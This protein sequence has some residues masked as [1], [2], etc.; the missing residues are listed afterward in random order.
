[1]SVLFNNSCNE[2]QAVNLLLAYTGNNKTWLAKQLNVTPQFL[3]LVHSNKP[4]K[5]YSRDHLI[6]ICKAFGVDWETFN[7][8]GCL[9]IKM[10]K[11]L[12]KDKK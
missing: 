3:H 12:V 7:K 9:N 8:M 6:T 2:V 4:G 5:R 1:M 11:S 10:S